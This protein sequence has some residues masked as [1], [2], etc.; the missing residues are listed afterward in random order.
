MKACSHEKFTSIIHPTCSGHG[1][2]SFPTDLPHAVSISHLHLKHLSILLLP[3]PAP[4]THR[5][6]PLLGLFGVNLLCSLPLGLLLLLLL[7]RLP[8]R[9]LLPLLPDQLQPLQICPRLIRLALCMQFLIPFLG[10]LRLE[11]FPLP[12]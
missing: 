5:S 6:S 3:S 8:L 9:I 4:T 7:G 12:P 11:R 10:L 2:N 1:S